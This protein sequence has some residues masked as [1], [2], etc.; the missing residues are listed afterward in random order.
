MRW[1]SLS[2]WILIAMG[3]LGSLAALLSIAR[4]G[5]GWDSPVDARALLEVRA[6]PPEVTLEEAYGAVQSTSEFYGILIPQL[7]EGVHGL[8]T[9]SSAALEPWSLATYRWQAGVT[10][11]L[12]TVAA[13]ALAWAT[14]HALSS[15]LAGAF[16]WAL[17]MTTPV[18]VGMSHVNFKD[19]PVAAGLSMFSAGLM[20]A[21]AGRG[22][23]TRWLAG[24]AL[25]SAGSVIALGTRPGSWPMIAGLAV[26]SIAALTAVALRRR[27]LP[28]VLPVA[29]GTAVAAGV[30]SAVLVLTNPFA[31]I[32]LAQWLSDAFSVMR[33][34]PWDGVTRAGGQD[35]VATDLPWWYVPGW[36]L[37]QAPVL[38]SIA[39]M[40]ALIAVAG[41]LARSRWSVPRA[42]LVN[43]TPVGV[44][45]VLLPLGIVLSGSVL[46]D[47]LRHVLFMIP[48]LAALASVGI[49]ALEQGH[50]RKATWP[51]TVALGASIIIVGASLFATLRWMPYSYAFTNP[52]ASVLGGER[53]WEL[54]YWGVSAIEGARLLQERGLTTVA[55]EPTVG[56]SDM[57]GVVWR[58]QAREQAPDGYGLYVFNRGDSSIG[59][60]ESLFTI[61]RDA[62]VLGEGARCTKWDG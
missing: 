46:Y 4:A 3:G 45:G 18:I 35:F 39:L 53:A 34:Y 21:W 27:S 33:Q 49:A 14:S 25:M 44:Q 29:T 6:L 16:T 52:I 31:R 37:A 1:R 11:V 57:V 28:A 55:V 20:L 26:I 17:V 58:D 24:P 38:T 36:L 40:W 7:A 23:W 12:A 9:G 2:T 5:I 54:D 62:Q 13:A 56:T 48:A 30:T 60:C 22:A 59:T 47:G 50:W 15:R 8:I 41:S 19:M 43:M 42:R 32:N 61:E 10:V 51:S